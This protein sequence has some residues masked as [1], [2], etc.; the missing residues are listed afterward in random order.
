MDCIQLILM[1]ALVISQCTYLL[2]FCERVTSFF[3]TVIYTSFFTQR[4]ESK[5]ASLVSPKLKRS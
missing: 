4:G 2:N 1:A 5:A 3:H